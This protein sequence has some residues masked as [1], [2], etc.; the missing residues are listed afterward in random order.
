MKLLLFFFYFLNF[1]ALGSKGSRGLIIIIII[2]LLLFWTHR[3]KTC[4]HKIEVRK[5]V[6]DATLLHSV[7]MVFQK[8]TTF[9]VWRTTEKR[10]N[11]KVVSLVSSVI[12]I[13]L[14]SPENV[15]N[16]KCTK[17][18][19]N[20]IIKQQK[21][22][23]M[24]MTHNDTHGYVWQ[25]NKQTII[26]NCSKV[27]RIKGLKPKIKNKVWSTKK[28]FLGSSDTAAKQPP[29]AFKKSNAEE[30][31]TPWLSNASDWKMQVAGRSA[32]LEIFLFAQFQQPLHQQTGMKGEHM[33][34]L[35]LWLA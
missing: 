15:D 14:Y 25:T 34:Q 13:Q 28:M 23:Y 29:T 20:K 10:W 18:K 22:Q 24:A 5:C 33:S 27:Q 19:L 1:N 30:W 9:P 26:V 12:I 31:V 8:E 32:Y 4:G 35:G 21:Q 17:V 6:M 11:K 2:T 16:L 3:H 7:I